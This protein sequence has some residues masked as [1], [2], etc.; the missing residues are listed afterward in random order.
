MQPCP[1]RDP[2]GQEH[3]D[4]LPDSGDDCCPG[5]S[6]LENWANAL[7]S[8]S[9]RL[10]IL[11]GA[12]VCRQSPPGGLTSLPAG[13]VQALSRPPQLR[14][15]ADPAAAWSGG[16]G[17]RQAGL[18]GGM[19]GRVPSPTGGWRQQPGS[20]GLQGPWATR[21]HGSLSRLCGPVFGSLWG[22]A[23]PWP[24]VQPAVT[25]AAHAIGCTSAPPRRGQAS[26]GRRDRP[27]LQD[28][29]RPPPGVRW[30]ARGG[31]GAGLRDPPGR[32]GPLSSR[33]PR[34][35]APLTSNTLIAR[36]SAGGLVGRRANSRVS[37]AFPSLSTR[38]PASADSED[39]AA[40]SAFSRSLRASWMRLCRLPTKRGD[41]G[42]RSAS[43]PRPRP[44]HS[45]GPAPAPPHLGLGARAASA[46]T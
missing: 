29:R 43:C 41:C 25:R 19:V 38:L 36:V 32:E 5:R 3:T 44:A 46:P 2:G 45:A 6:R 40:A 26:H 14:V 8:G 42:E 30:W 27:F 34:P 12:S 15:G 11:D 23:S 21:P 7:V 13:L 35:P 33:S 24:P 18:G 20:L 39:E 37:T 16:S 4:Y 10:S 31:W 9:P 22:G 1:A 28:P 17:A